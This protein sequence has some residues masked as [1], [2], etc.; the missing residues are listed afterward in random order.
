M[1]CR[2]I[3]RTLLGLE[4]GR[5]GRGGGEREGRGREERGRENEKRKER[6]VQ[7]RLRREEG[8]RSVGMNS[9]LWSD[10]FVP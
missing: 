6:G 3:H 8:G 5:E 10:L 4:G 7:E 1:V 2:P 9:Q